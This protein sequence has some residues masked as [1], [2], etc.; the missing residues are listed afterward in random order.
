VNASGLVRRHFDLRGLAL[1][2]AILL[3]LE[4]LAAATHFH[5]DGLARPSEILFAAV[6]ALADGSMLRATGET[7]AAAL[8]GLAIGSLIGL[9]FGFMLG[10]NLRAFWACEVTVEIV[11][12]IPSVALIPVVL[13]I[14]GLGYPM[15]ISL[16]A[17]TALWPVLFFTVAAVRGV[18]ARLLEYSRLLGLGLFARACHII[19]PAALPGIFVGFRISIAASLIVAITVEIA[20][21]PQ[22]LGNAMMRAEE[23]LRPELTFAYLF[24]V[25]LVGWLIHAA[26]VRLQAGLFASAPSAEGNPT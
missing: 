21:N 11:R 17:K 15:E 23:A 26:V 5:S 20:A 22:G 8:G 25:A 14:F 18:K 13:L 16:I 1:P 9:V 24:W 3:L 2:A 4:A 10:L 12:P 19:L 7:L 6:N